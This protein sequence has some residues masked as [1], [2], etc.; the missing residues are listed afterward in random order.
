MR[1]IKFRAWVKNAKRMEHCIEVNPFYIGDCD[2]VRWNR[3]KVELTQYTGLKDKNGKDIYE[4][5]ICT[6][7]AEEPH[8]NDY[9]TTDY[10]WKMT[11]YVDFKYGAFSFRE[12]EDE[13]IS[14]Y[15]IETQDMDIEV[16][17]NIYE[18]PELMKGD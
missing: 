13:H 17:G 18:S 6:V 1:E 12:V 2:R 4:G 9:F 15:Y 11:M 7:S 5:D 10:D 8:S 14:I 16:I 3:D